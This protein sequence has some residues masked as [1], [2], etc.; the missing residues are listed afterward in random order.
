MPWAITYSKA[1]IAD[2]IGLA[3]DYH[4]TIVPE[5]DVPAHSGAML[6][7]HPDLALQGQGDMLDLGNPAAYVLIADLLNEYLPLFPGP[8]WHT[9]TDEYLARN[10]YSLYP[11]L[12]TYARQLYGPAASYQDIYT[13]KNRCASREV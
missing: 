8:F 5:I 7:R 1:E 3:R 11:Q 9:G 4:V 13:H 12:L 2:L 6:A 10:D